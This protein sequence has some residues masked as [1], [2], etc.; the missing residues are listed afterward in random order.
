[1][2]APEKPVADTSS[3]CGAGWEKRLYSPAMARGAPA[4][5]L[6]D[7]TALIGAEVDVAVR[8][9][10]TA[11][12]ARLTGRGG[13]GVLSM[14]ALAKA[15][16]TSPTTLHRLELGQLR[17]G[18]LL[19]GYETAL[20]LAPGSLRSPVDVTCRTFP[21]L[22]PVDQDAGAALTSV[23][24]VSDATQQLLAGETTGGLWLAWAR[25]LAQ[26]GAV[27]LPESLARELVAVLAGELGRSVGAAYP[28]RYEALALLR[29]SGYGHVVVEVA[30]GIVADP[31]VQVLNDL[32]SSVGESLDDGALDWC[33]RLLA[34]PRDHVVIGGALALENMAQVSPDPTV[35][36]RVAGPLVELVNDSP[37]GSVRREWFSH[38]VRLMPPA[39]RERVRRGVRQPLAPAPRLQNPSKSRVNA[40]WNDCQGRAH[41]V[42]S[43]LRL[44]DQPVL[45][46]LL[47]DI[48]HSPLES[49]AVTSYMLLGALPALAA[50]VVEQLT[51]LVEAHADPLVRRRLARRLA[52]SRMPLPPGVAGRWLGE[53]PTD[54]LEAGLL[55]AGTAG[56]RVDAHVLAGCWARAGS[57]VRAA[58]FAAGMAQDP[59]LHDLAG[60]PRHVAAR[61]ARWWLGQGGRVTDGPSHA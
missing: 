47:F 59:V 28:A 39:V 27:G 29:C 30:Q 23:R 31:E 60:H 9:G 16:G 10:W 43:A 52:G 50:P 55:L 44:P 36:L 7:T 48:A 1:M 3:G 5:V 22:S 45:A 54:L 57:T 8:I 6:D 35:W 42:T 51:G 13:D 34:D 18:T 15:V 41:A 26:P 21:D 14:Q 20:G 37:D 33:V 25:A 58:L 32:M 24:Q 4:A 2:L 19:D 49:R 56:E 38:L 46:R 61:G 11:R 17:H 53:A 12:M 40:E